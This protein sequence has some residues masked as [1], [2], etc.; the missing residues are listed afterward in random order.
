MSCRGVGAMASGKRLLLALALAVLVGGCAT[1]PP[2]ASLTSG[3]GLHSRPASQ[4]D[5]A[6]AGQRAASTAP[7]ETEG[8]AGG[9]PEQME[10]LFQTKDSFQVVQ[11]ASG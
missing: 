5:G 1:A 9:F 4:R 10:E 6:G 3:F 8:S 7:G 11:E 2:R